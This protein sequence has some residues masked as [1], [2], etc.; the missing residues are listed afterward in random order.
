MEG[1]HETRSF[2]KRSID[3]R[4]LNATDISALAEAAVNMRPLRDDI[5][6]NYRQ[7]ANCT[8]NATKSI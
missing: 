2:L 5:T 6:T 8:V 7:P 4:Y 1:I 3:N